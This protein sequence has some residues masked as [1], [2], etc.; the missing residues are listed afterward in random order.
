MI[1]AAVFTAVEKHIFEHA[2]RVYPIYFEYPY[3]KIG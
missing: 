3:E 2:N 1:P